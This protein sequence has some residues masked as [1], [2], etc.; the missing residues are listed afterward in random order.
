MPAP[1]RRNIVALKVCQIR[2]CLISECPWR[3]ARAKPLPGD[4]GNEV[5]RPVDLTLIAWKSRLE[6]RPKSIFAIRAFQIAGKGK[7]N[8]PKS[9]LLQ[10]TQFRHCP[11]RFL[12]R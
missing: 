4:V 2:E 11:I 6:R 5:D 3:V 9:E 7:A 8:T 10:S 1:Y 12:S